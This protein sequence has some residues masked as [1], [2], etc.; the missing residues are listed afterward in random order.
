MPRTGRPKPVLELTEEERDQLLRWERRPK[1]SQAL[2]LRSRIVL[3]CA[4]G[5]ANRE[6][7]AQCGVSAAPVG[8]WRRRFWVLWCGRVGGGVGAGQPRKSPGDAGG[9]G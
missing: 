2:A 5:A 8:E 7:A 6:V 1:S 3:A 9:A 4:Q